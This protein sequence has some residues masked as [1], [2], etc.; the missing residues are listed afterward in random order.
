MPC[1]DLRPVVERKVAS[2]AS[3]K[4]PDVFAKKSP[5]KDESILRKLTWS[6]PPHPF[7]LRIGFE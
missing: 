3:R 6:L 7:N 5:V 2:R 1:N 4:M